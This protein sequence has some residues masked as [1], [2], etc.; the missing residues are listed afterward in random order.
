M[1][2]I[3]TGGGSGGHIIPLI[4]VAQKIQQFAKDR[5]IENISFLYVGPRFLSI[6]EDMGEMFKRAGIERKYILSGKIRRYASAL[7]IIDVLKFPFIMLHA[8]WIVFW[9]MPDAVFSKG[10]FGSFPVMFACWLFFV[11][12]RVIH[13]SDSVPGLA[14]RM[15][16]IFAKRIGVAFTTA[17]LK[18]PIE[19]TAAVGLPVRDDLCRQDPKKARLF[20]DI[21]TDR[22]VIFIIGGSQGADI[23]NQNIIQIL[24]QLLSK[25]EIIHLCG[26]RNYENFK[27]QLKEM[28]GD[29]LSGSYHLYPFLTEE[30]KF[31]FTLANIVVSR[32]SATSIFEI[33]SC[34][35]P[36]IL[37]PLKN[38]AQDHQRQNAYEYSKTGAAIVMEENNLTPHLL[39]S[40]IESILENKETADKISSNAAAFITKNSAEII[41]KEILQLRGIV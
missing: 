21:Q 1:K 22:K 28:H 19:K 5:G 29:K 24:P 6:S 35:K 37:I 17:A 40:N 8:L 13:E 31:A 30:I 33:A 12:A 26:Q 34:A 36:S 3:L 39:F 41:A 32:A 11:P 16:A 7:N 23:I 20:F 25:Y 10:G 38:S 2:V 9:N 18:F 15:S 14:N 27:S 4:T